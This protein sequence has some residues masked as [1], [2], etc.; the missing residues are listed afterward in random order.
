MTE[1]SEIDVFTV[2]AYNFLV[3]SLYYK[4]FKSSPTPNVEKSVFVPP[5]FNPNWGVYEYT[6][7]ASKYET[8]S[9][10][11]SLFKIKLALEIYTDLLVN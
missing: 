10:Y 6:P 5:Y 3:V 11:E 1:L 8:L 4:N 2:A 9:N 7:V